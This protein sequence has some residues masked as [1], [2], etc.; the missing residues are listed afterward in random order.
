MKENSINALRPKH[1]V[2]QIQ[3]L[4]LHNTVE[5]ATKY[6]FNSSAGVIS[7]VI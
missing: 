3:N 6:C 4:E 2:D 1:K 5:L 7:T